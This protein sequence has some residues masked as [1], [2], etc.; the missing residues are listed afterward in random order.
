M[1]IFNLLKDI[2]KKKKKIK[3][4][5]IDTTSSI[6]SVAIL[7]NNYLISHSSLDNGL[8]HSENLMPLV[9]DILKK[10]DLTLKDINLLAVC[11][12]P[13]SFTG[14]RIGVATA[15]PIAEFNNIPICG[16]TSLE[17]LARNYSI[18]DEFSY[19][20]NS[21][22]GGITNKENFMAALDTIK[23]YSQ[24]VTTVNIVSMID[25]K[26][27][28]VYC[29]I[30]DSIYKLLEPEMACDF[31]EAMEKIQKYD[32]VVFVGDGAIEHKEEIEELMQGK[33]IR[34]IENNAQSAVNV[35]KSAYDSYLKDDLKT[36][37]EVNPSYLRKSQAER[38]KENT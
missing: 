15:K 34:F 17:C 18:N 22:H 9:E 20:L 37:D 14:I 4:L 8:T 23:D 11:V 31:K 6:C 38:L 21:I 19:N 26:N 12:G 3:I 13:G 30:F 2:D 27:N 28:L 5:A 7:E 10:N 16:V 25:A 35:A 24:N 32:N 1:G 33:K 36:P 29:G